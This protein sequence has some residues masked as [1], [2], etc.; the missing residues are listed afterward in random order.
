MT[1]KALG[2]IAYRI[3]NNADLV[4]VL[5]VDDEDKYL[6]T[7]EDG[8]LSFELLMPHGASAL[9]TEFSQIE[10][11]V[12]GRKV[13]DIRWDRTGFFKTILYEQGEWEQEL[14]DW[15]EPIPF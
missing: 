14:L 1:I 11:R 7:L 10:I 13:F 12:D 8:S 9:P 6:R 2:R 15:P 5:T 3:L 4:G